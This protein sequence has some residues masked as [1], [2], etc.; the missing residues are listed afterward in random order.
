[1]PKA[2]YR[3]NGSLTLVGTL[4]FMDKTP[5]D[6]FRD[7]VMHDGKVNGGNIPIITK[8]QSTAILTMVSN[9]IALSWPDFAVMTVTR[10]CK[11]YVGCD[12]LSMRS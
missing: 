1:M 10:S 12:W 4:Q 5:A 2:L 9:I 8:L 3:P 6:D 11:R 7:I